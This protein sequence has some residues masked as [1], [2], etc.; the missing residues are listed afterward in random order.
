MTARCSAT[1][2]KVAS[3]ASAS[4]SRLSNP[5]IYA[6]AA[7]LGDQRR[8]RVPQI[9]QIDII[10]DRAL[11]DVGI[12]LGEET[13]G[14]IIPRQDRDVDVTVLPHVAARTR[15]EQPYRRIMLAERGEHHPP[16]FLDRLLPRRVH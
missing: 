5:A 13:Y 11:L 1:S 9:D 6:F 12:E 4:V 14:Q 8:V 16:Q 15:P 7:D 2:S 3:A 10:G